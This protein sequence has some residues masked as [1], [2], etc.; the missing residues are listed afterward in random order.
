[1]K[2][3]NT[4]V[5]FAFVILVLLPFVAGAQDSVSPL[6]RTQKILELK[7]KSNYNKLLDDVG[8]DTRDHPAKLIY[9]DEEGE[10]E[11][12]KIELETRGNFR[13]NPSNCDFPPLQLEFEDFSNTTNTVF[14]GQEELKLV[15]HCQQEIPGYEDHVRIEFLMYRI[16]NELTPYSFK[17]RFC[18]MNYKSRWWFTSNHK[19][20]FLIEDNDMLAARFGGEELDDDDDYLPV[21]S[22]QYAI[23]AFFEYMIGNTDWSVVPMQN[24]EIIETADG[25]KVPVPYDFD[26]SA[27]VNPPYAPEAMQKDSLEFLKREYRGPAFQRQ[28][29][30]SVTNLFLSKREKIRYL[31]A[32]SILLK[33]ADKKRL[34]DYITSFFEELEAPGSNPVWL[35][36]NS[37]E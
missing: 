28:I 8:E 35:R 31:I 33:K 2:Q 23:V 15:T 26:L 22:T 7:M 24:M 36:K 21:D 16:Y 25:T 12:I 29:V 30:D 14:E 10:K 32:E 20:A 9:T 19:P 11:K 37:N 34:N 5:T 3:S 1:M 27:S 13:S 4:P 6:F 17:T 18:H